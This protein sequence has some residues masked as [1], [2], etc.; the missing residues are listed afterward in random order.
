M[1]A[2][3]Q[4]VACCYMQFMLSMAVTGGLYELINAGTILMS[5]A[6]ILNVKGHDVVT[7]HSAMPVEQIARKLANRRIGVIV[8]VDE[9]GQVE[10]IVSERD[11]VR[12]VAGRQ[13]EAMAV[14]ADTIMTRNL[15]TCKPEDSV[16]TLMGTMTKHHV[17][18]VPVVVDGKLCGLVSIG[19]VVKSRIADAEREAEDMKRYIAG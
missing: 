6:D 16:P 4:P 7:G 2:I 13:N 14:T 1:A 12:I 3:G 11:I 15:I 18:H 5:V 10:G 9:Q 19:D 8:I 17:R